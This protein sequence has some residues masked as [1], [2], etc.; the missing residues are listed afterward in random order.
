MTL[1]QPKIMVVDDDPGMRLTLGGIIEEEGYEIVEA[2]DGFQAIA[3]AKENSLDLIFM[4]VIMPHMHGVDAFREI[5]RF[6]PGTAVV[7]MTGFSKGELVKNALDE[8]VYSLMLKPFKVSRIIDIL[9]AVLKT[10]MVLAVSH[11]AWER[12]IWREVL[13]KGGYVVS[14]ASDAIEGVEMAAAKHYDVIILDSDLPNTEGYGLLGQIRV[15][16]PLV[17]VVMIVAD[18]AAVPDP[19]GV[20]LGSYSLLTSPVDPNQMLDVIRANMGPQEST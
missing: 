7:I 13:E 5:K 10:K 15:F 19:A 18:S 1:N 12:E 2:S 17:K 20:D 16:D 9:R 3:L 8:G 6:S 11:R 14:T 4:D